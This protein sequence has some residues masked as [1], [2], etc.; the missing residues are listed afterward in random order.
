LLAVS[1][2]IACL[3]ACFDKRARGG[4]CRAVIAL[5]AGLVIAYVMTKHPGDWLRVACDALSPNLLVLC[6]A[7]ALG[8]GILHVRF[9]DA[10]AWVWIGGFAT[11]GAVGIGA[12]FAVDPSCA[13]GAFAGMGPIV[14]T[15][16][17][18]GVVEG[19][20]LIEFA[21][22]QPSL[23][24]GFLAVMAISLI[25]LI[26]QA[27]STRTT[28]HVF[29]AASTLLAGLYGFYYIKF[30]PYG[31]LLAL[32]PL[33]CWIARLPAIGDTSAFSVRLGAILLTSQ[34]FFVMIAGLAIGLVS[35]VEADA[36]S[37]LSSSVSSC[38]TKT[39]IAALSRLPTGLIISDIDLGPFIAASTRHRAYAGPYHRI[40][41]SIRDLLVLQTAPLADAGRHLA[42]MDA[43]YLVL[44]GAVPDANAKQPMAKADTFS[45]H[46]RR[47]G[48]FAGLQPV[49]IGSIKGP[50]KVW[51]IVKEN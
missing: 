11:A 10:A 24:F 44:C 3:L 46:M 12:Y 49:S 34:T 42:K 32:V 51:K 33:A 18:D 50:L 28:D 21:R 39:D 41:T 5:A 22:I 47:G 20:T 27:I 43:D 26:R 29:M 38:T 25:V 35:D 7:G 9:R 31:A 23:T 6:G 1:L 37:K 36:K 16:W 13:A 14:K 8:T 48:A 17:L 4:A 15:Q 19:K 40:H 45:K 30:M 2:G